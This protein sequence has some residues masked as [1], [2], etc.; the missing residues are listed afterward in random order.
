MKFYPDALKNKFVPY[1][2]RC[3]NE[4]IEIKE[5]L[6]NNKRLQGTQEFNEK[7]ERAESLHEIVYDL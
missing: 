2:Q 3:E 5:W 6:R 1:S 7:I 4:L